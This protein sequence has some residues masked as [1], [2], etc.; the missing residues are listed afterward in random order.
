MAGI[1]RSERKAKTAQAP[2]HPNAGTCPACGAAVVWVETVGDVVPCEPQRRLV[3][4][5]AS[6][7]E[8][9]A[10]VDASGNA[11]EALAVF[12]EHTGEL[13]WGRAATKAE[14]RRFAKSGNPGVPFVIGRQ[15]HWMTCE[16]LD[17]YVSG[18][19]RVRERETLA[20]A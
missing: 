14:G 6:F 20:P 8:H 19:A 9:G 5:D 16:R 15:G 2:P 1:R 7:D 17:R 11:V 4:F 18:E 10:L 12:H 3:V 13:V